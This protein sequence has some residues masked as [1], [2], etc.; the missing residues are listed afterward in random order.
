[1]PSGA[2]KARTDADVIAYGGGLRAGAPWACRVPRHP[3]D[4]THRGKDCWLLDLGEWDYGDG[5]GVWGKAW[6]I[7]GGIVEGTG[8][9][10]GGDRLRGVET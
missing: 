7:Q 3:R 2:P 10:E 4:S 9:I 1:M 6:V 5:R 8:L